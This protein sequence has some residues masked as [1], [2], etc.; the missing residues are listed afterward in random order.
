MTRERLLLLAVGLAMVGLLGALLDRALRTVEREEALR[1][2]MI[3]DRVFDELERGLQELVDREEARP[4]LHYSYAYV[5]DNDAGPV[6]VSRSPLAE[7]PEG[8]LVGYFQISPDGSLSTPYRPA[9]GSTVNP[10]EVVDRIEARLATATAGLAELARKAPD[11]SDRDEA[12]KKA[13]AEAEREQAEKRRK[14]RKPAPAPVPRPVP[15]PDATLG[16]LNRGL[17]TSTARVSKT[18]TVPLLQAGNFVSNSAPED[19]LQV[20]TAVQATLDNANPGTPPRPQQAT[21]D[22]DIASLPARS[23]VEVLVEPFAVDARDAEL[24]LYRTVLLGQNR[25]VQGLVLDRAGLLERLEGRVLTDELA[26]V[27]TLSWAGD[28]PYHHTFRTPFDSLAVGLDLAG[29][30]A[31]QSTR[32]FWMLALVLLA[33]VGIAAALASRWLAE[34]ALLARQRADFVAAV[35][36][37][38]RSPL[39]SIRMYSEMLEHGMVPGE[40]T[41]L[42]YYR[43]IRQESERLSRLVEDVLA[44][45][46][47]ERGQDRA[48]TAGKLGE[49]VDEVGRLFRPI[50]ERDGFDLEVRVQADARDLAVSDRDALVQVLTNLVDNALKFSRDREVRRVA[51]SA[52][53][54][55]AGVE[56]AVRDSGPGVDP[57]FLP[58]IFDAFTRGE[59]E[60]TRKTKG[61]GIGLALVRGLVAELG[62]QVRAHNLADGFE[63]VVSLPA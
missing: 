27:A 4:F 56:L 31:R 63:V 7:L 52:Q 20:Q 34:T 59:A 60:L 15:T 10:S 46:K 2:A 23:E 55:D 28:G 17:N 3:A 53:R 29:L 40:D 5:P 38:L 62:G 48:G 14:Q 12:A 33:V 37:E 54:S 49:V 11:R 41:K 25:W 58:R 18:E 45:S 36:H 22:A 6:G 30:P 13:R 21:M 8:E 42:G 9:T 43:T 47:L 51:V 35:S 19:F 16:S 61:T 39:T 57:S 32:P 50:T 26:S 1:H 44:F 24:V